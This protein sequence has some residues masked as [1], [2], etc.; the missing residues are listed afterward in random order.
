MTIRGGTMA[1]ELAAAKDRLE[2]IE[3]RLLEMEDALDRLKLLCRVGSL[4]TDGMHG[5]SEDPAATALA[6]Y[7]D[8]L[9]EKIEQV[10][11]LSPRTHADE[12]R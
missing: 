1:D 11:D 10:R 6:I 12:R 3:S 5:L 9:A 7:F 2:R 8:V 4:A